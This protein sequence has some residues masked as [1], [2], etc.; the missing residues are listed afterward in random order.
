MHAGN[1]DV[2][3][4]SPDVTP[5]LSRG[6]RSLTIHESSFAALCVDVRRQ[7]TRTLAGNRSVQ[8]DFLPRRPND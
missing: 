6:R 3:A 7:T 2:E 4:G 1:S 8:P 5:A